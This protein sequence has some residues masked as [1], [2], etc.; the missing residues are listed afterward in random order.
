MA[1]TYDITPGSVEPT[2][3]AHSSPVYV[4]KAKVPMLPLSQEAEEEEPIGEDIVQ[5]LFGWVGPRR[6]G[7]GHCGNVSDGSRAVS[8]KIS[9]QPAD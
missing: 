8:A 1:S 6:S 9:P 2:T 5:V 4:L 7:W 3:P